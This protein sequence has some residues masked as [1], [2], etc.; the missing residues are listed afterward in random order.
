MSLFPG[1]PRRSL[2]VERTH[3]TPSAA[4][5]GYKGE[6]GGQD[7]AGSRA[8]DGQQF[9]GKGLGIGIG[10]EIAQNGSSRRAEGQGHMRE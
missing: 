7:G 4:A 1:T 2:L 10:D 9:D 8:H 5:T 3:S 6:G